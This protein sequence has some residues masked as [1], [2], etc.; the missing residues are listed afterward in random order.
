VI[1]VAVQT[2]RSRSA[3]HLA[4]A[5]DTFHSLKPPSKILRPLSRVRKIC[6]DYSQIIVLRRTHDVHRPAGVAETQHQTAMA[7]W[8]LG[9]I[10]YKLAV[11][12]DRFYLER[13]NHALGTR[14]LANSIRQK[15]YSFL[16][17]LPNVFLNRQ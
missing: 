15:Q 9:I 13:R 3:F 16:R 11:H 7:A 10:F 12:D 4:F 8:I 1:P 14:H 2:K 17:R 6:R 5:V